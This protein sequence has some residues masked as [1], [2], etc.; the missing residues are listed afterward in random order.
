MT[1]TRIE[2]LADLLVNYSVGVRAGDRVVI[3]GG[4]PAEPL[5]LAV[6]ARVLQ[7]GGQP[8]L[9]P[10]LPEANEVFYRHA[11]ETQLQHISPV[12]K[13]IRETFEVM[14]QIDAVPNTRAL[15]H[16]DPARLAR[17]AQA[18]NGL[19]RTLMQRTARGEL[20]WVYTLFP[21]HG[22]AQDADMSLREFEDFFYHACMPEPEDPI[23]YW[24]QMAAAQDEIIAWLKGKKSVRV[25]APETDLRL[26]IAGRPF[27]NCAGTFNLPDGEVFTAPV[28]DSVTGHVCFS[29]PAIY[30][31][32]EVSGVRLWFEAGRVVRA[33]AERNEALLLAILDTDAGARRVGEFAIA[34]N[35]GITRFTRQILFDEKIGGTFHL[36]LGASYP[37]S[38]GVNESAIHWDM[39]C[40]LRHG[41]EIWVDD[42]LIYRNGKF[43]LRGK[44]LAFINRNR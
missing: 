33:T 8:L 34:T 13:L 12:E 39:I 23:G 27:I 35:P 36:A 20:R 37:E 41:G 28:E 5:L 29:Y 14:I 32:Q 21:T 26:S 15:S 1:D 6:Y 2:K 25:K 24:Q 11:S 44:S 30:H 43:L 10:E 4:T 17:R 7:V 38:G 19:N 16:I 18:R 40:D 42:E 22:Y 3:Q 9:W 31:D